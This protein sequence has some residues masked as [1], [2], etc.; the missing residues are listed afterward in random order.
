[1]IECTVTLKSMHLLLLSIAFIL[2]FIRGENGINNF[3]IAH[4]MYLAEYYRYDLKV[5]M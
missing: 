4:I 5:D 2:L 1:M 3:I